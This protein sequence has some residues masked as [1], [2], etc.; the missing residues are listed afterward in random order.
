MNVPSSLVTLPRLIIGV[1]PAL[2]RDIS[3]L[4]QQLFCCGL[5]E[6]LARAGIILHVLHVFRRLQGI[7][8]S[9]LISLG[10]NYSQW[11]ETGIAGCDLSDML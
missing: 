6:L 9:E 10:S 5:L 11:R 4:N 3:V 8:L 1:A 7:S 2:K